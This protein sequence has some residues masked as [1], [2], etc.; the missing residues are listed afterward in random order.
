MRIIL[1]AVAVAS[2]T[3]N[4][5]NAAEACGGYGSSIVEWIEQSAEKFSA[6]GKQFDGNSDG[7]PF[8]ALMDAVKD[9]VDPKLREAWREV[10]RQQQQR[11]DG[12]PSSQLMPR[13]LIMPSGYPGPRG[14]NDHGYA[15]RGLFEPGHPLFEKTLPSCFPKLATLITNHKS[16][17]TS[18]L[19]A[20]AERKAEVQRQATEAERLRAVAETQRQEAAR[21]S[22]AEREVENA[23]PQGQLRRAY[24]LY[25]LLR[26]CHATREG[27]LVQYINDVEMQRVDAAIKAIVGKWRKVEPEMD[28]DLLWR[29]ANQMT[30]GRYVSTNVCSSGYQE[31]VSMSPI[32]AIRIEKPN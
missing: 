29:Q 25:I 3:F 18:E 1:A 22:A 30:A 28:T 20:E 12:V 10:L 31:L 11:G 4:V 6:E 13:H 27:Y 23:S 9:E 16:R 7:F 24:S 17:M 15:W 26:W 21:R 8:R 14:L 2:L 5:A 19:K 32:P